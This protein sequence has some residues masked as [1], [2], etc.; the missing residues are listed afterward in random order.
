MWSPKL[1]RHSHWIIC[2]IMGLLLTTLTVCATGGPQLVDHAFGFDA[3][4]DSPDAQILDYR[5]GDSQLPGARASKSEIRREV[6]RQGTNING[7]MRRGDSLYVKWRIKSTGQIYEDTVD[8][9][10]RLPRD[11]THDRIHF[12]VKGSQLYVYLIT[13]EKLR[14]NPCP[15]PIERHKLRKSVNPNDRIFA[16]YCSLKIATLYPDQPKQ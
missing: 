12:I 15:P 1:H 16:T 4:R 3:V 13:S 2:L 5:Y 11:I 14:P 10:S 7:P 6:V 8:L 9:K